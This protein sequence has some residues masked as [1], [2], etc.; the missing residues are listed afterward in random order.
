MDFQQVSQQL[1]FISRRPV[2]VPESNTAMATEK[3]HV[4]GIRDVC[5]TY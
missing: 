1:S 3:T 2:G 4:S 5:N